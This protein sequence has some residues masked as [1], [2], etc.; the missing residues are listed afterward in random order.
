LGKGQ[1]HRNRQRKPPKVRS[2]RRSGEVEAS[3]QAFAHGVSG[4]TTG[5]GIARQQAFGGDIRNCSQ[6][7]QGLRRDLRARFKALNGAQVQPAEA[8]Q[9]LL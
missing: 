5:G 4:G 3:L 2:R 9:L 8:G 7:T 1:R 6:C